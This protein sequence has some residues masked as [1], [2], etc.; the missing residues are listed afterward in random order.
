MRQGRLRSTLLV[1]SSALALVVAI[2][3]SAEA[4]TCTVVTN[5]ALPFSYSGNTCVTFTA[6]P[7]TS[8]DITN[9]GTVTASGTTNPNSTGISLYVGP[10]V[11]GNIVN[12]GTINAFNEGIFLD[13]AKL[14]GS[15]T[16]FTGATINSTL[17]PSGG[18][19]N[20]QGS[21]VSGSVINN[22]KIT[23]FNVGLAVGASTVGGDV[24]N[25]STVTSGPD[26]AM[27]ISEA[28]VAGSVINHGTL[29]A[30]SATVGIAISNGG[31][32]GG[33]V[34]NFGSVSEGN[35]F[36]AVIQVLP[37]TAGIAQ[38]ITGSIINEVGGTLTG[39]V[40]IAILAFVDPSTTSTPV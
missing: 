18:G 21:K 9:N 26:A 31:S 33:S 11:T 5:P 29:S 35:A 7:G 37:S 28:T 15:I 32:I 39:G 1:T 19:I 22:G 8:G 3:Q 17:G 30:V 4:A 13:Q 24:I 2:D 40:G 23:S 12:K 20:V 14:N 16:N 27:A 10:T 38:T 36:G 6:S 25:N 34:E